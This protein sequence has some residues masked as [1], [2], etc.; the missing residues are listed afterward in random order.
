VT[1][2]LESFAD[3]DQVGQLHTPHDI[4][5]RMAVRTRI[6]SLA[7]PRRNLAEKTVDFSCCD[8]SN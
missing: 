3:S 2:S 7:P 5:P 4:W 6:E 1:A 8:G